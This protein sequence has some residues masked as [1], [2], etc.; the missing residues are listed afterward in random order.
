MFRLEST[1]RYSWTTRILFLSGMMLVSLV[2][3]SVPYTGYSFSLDTSSIKVNSKVVSNTSQCSTSSDA[4]DVTWHRPAQTEINSLESVING[5]GIY[6]FI[7]DSST[8]PDS[9]PYSTYNWCNMPRVRAQEYKVPDP[10]YQLQY[11]EVVSTPIKLHN[12]RSMSL[13]HPLIPPDPPSPQTNPL[14]LKHLPHR[15]TL[16]VLFNL[17]PLLLRDLRYRPCQ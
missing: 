2:L 6:G 10:D 13:T 3:L 8:T 4:V 1:S 15:T 7:F 17:P 9:V 11:V 5:S 12:H 14:R 16:L